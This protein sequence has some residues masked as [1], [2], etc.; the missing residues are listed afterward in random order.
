MKSE[1]SGKE[2]SKFSRSRRNLLKLFG[3]TVI[4]ILLIEI[5]RITLGIWVVKPVVA[6]WGVIEK[7][8]WVEALFL[9]D[10]IIIKSEFEGNINQKA[11]NGSRIAK[12]AV[13]ASINTRFGLAMEPDDAAFRLERRLLLL[14]SEDGALASELKRINNEI[15][16]RKNSLLKTSTKTSEIKEDLGSLEQEKRQILRNIKSV[17]EQILKTQVAIKNEMKGFKSVVA[18][19]VGYLFFQYDNWEGKLSPDHFFELSEEEFR[20]NY[21]LKSTGN[22]V[23]PGAIIAKIISPFTQTIAVMIDTSI[24]GT[25]KLGDSWG[26]KTSDG[27]HSVIIKNII[28]MDNRKMILAFDDSGIYQ[29]HIPTRRSKIFIIYRKI[30]GI[31]VPTQALYING[32]QTFV[33]LRKGDGYSLQEVQVLETDGDKA[34]VEGIDFGTTILSR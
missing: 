30:N 29:Q 3:Y 13:I 24:T 32:R 21:H 14:R 8:C 17:R 5:G 1:Y 16:F 26:I 11:E 4:L 10:E 27:L 15:N 31:T 34:V 33:K 22:R 9:R 28:P 6:Q 12:G 19:E 2:R 7:G 23:K 18:P 25:P 20:N